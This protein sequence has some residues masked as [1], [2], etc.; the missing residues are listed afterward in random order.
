M[1]QPIKSTTHLFAFQPFQLDRRC[2]RYARERA[3]PHT[4]ARGIKRYAILRAS[5]HRHCFESD[6]F[7]ADD[8]DKLHLGGPVD[9]AGLVCQT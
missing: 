8:G 4:V 3:P 1:A 5:L 7:A 6:F 9:V 2:A